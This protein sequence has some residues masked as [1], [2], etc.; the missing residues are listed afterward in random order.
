M[1]PIADFSRLHRIRRSPRRLDDNPEAASALLS[2]MTSY[3]RSEFYKFL[4]AACFKFSTLDE[5]SQSLKD[6]SWLKGMD[7]RWV[8]KMAAVFQ[9]S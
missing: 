1:N 2:N 8:F 3:Y 4:D 7:E 6:R 9:D 5:R